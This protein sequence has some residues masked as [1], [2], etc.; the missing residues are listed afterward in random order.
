MTRCQ[1]HR[2]RPLAAPAQSTQSTRATCACVMPS[3]QAAGAR[4]T[5][6]RRQP[7]GQ[8]VLQQLDTSARPQQ[9]PGQALQ[10]LALAGSLAGLLDGP[11]AGS[12]ILV[13][14]GVGAA[15]QSEVT[16]Q[17]R[18]LVL[19]RRLHLWWQQLRELRHAVHVCS[20]GVRGVG[21][22]VGWL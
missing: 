4:P 19:W 10:Q 9:V 22:W 13:Q 17:V 2:A 18:R 11:L 1:G 20:R 3:L 7:T 21:G 12:A 5:R 8:E 16:A 6:P 14:V 15:V